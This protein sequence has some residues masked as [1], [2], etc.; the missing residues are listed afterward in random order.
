MVG[1]LL[2]GCAGRTAQVIARATS[3][4]PVTALR[5]LALSPHAKPSPAETTLRTN[6]IA[7][8][9][10]RGFELVAP[11]NADYTLAFWLE[12][13]WKPGKRVEYFYHGRWTTVYPMPARLPVAVGPWGTVYEE[14]PAFVRQR[15]VDFPYFIQGIRLKL[16]PGA[17]HQPGGHSLEPVWEGYI[18]GGTKIRKNQQPRLLRALLDYFGQNFDGRA[19]LSRSV[20]GAP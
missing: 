10:R 1:T 6:L 13:S 7:E 18:E 5:R 2:T 14:D 16:Y 15:V 11:P 9:E 3:Q 12:D 4:S 20:S 8:L 19:P 17:N